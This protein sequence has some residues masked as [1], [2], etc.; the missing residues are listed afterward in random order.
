MKGLKKIL[1]IALLS[2]FFYGCGAVLVGGLLMRSASSEKER[3]KFLIQLQKT[4]IEREK[5]GLP[6]LNK[7]VEIYHF[8]PSWAEDLEDCQSTID[9][10]IKAGVKSNTKYKKNDE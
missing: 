8:D 5:N 2:I 1:I 6:P 7:C 9:S 10:L 4:N 3:T